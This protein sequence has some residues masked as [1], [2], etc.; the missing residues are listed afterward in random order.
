[1]PPYPKAGRMKKS[2]LALALLL[3]T[4]LHAEPAW[5]ERSNQN[6]RYLIEEQAR[7]VP[8]EA[9]VNGLTRYDGQTMDLGPQLSERR[10]R[11][12]EQ[13][14]AELRKRLA[15]EKVGNV[16]QDLQ[17]LIASVERDSKRL[18]LHSK[19]LLAW[20]DAPGLIFS[21][22]R[23][24]LNDQTPPERRA[25]AVE[26]LQ[27]YVGQ[28]PGSKPLTEL[29]KA[30]FL[31]RRGLLG[32]TRLSVEDSLANSATYVQGIRQLFQKY[33]LKGADASLTLLEQQVADYT[34]WQKTVVLPV[35][36][37][38]F[39]LPPELYAFTLQQWG[40]DVQPEALIQRALLE[41]M[42]T[43]AALQQL[44][45]LVA[46]QKGFSETE[47]PKV[48][49][50]LK[51]EK[52][53]NDRLEAEYQE[54]NNQIEAVIRREKLVDLPNRPMQV[55]LASEA[56][57]AS[58]PAPHMDPPPL[59]NNHGEQG[60]FVLP[61]SVAGQEYDD[62]NF[63]GATWT[64]SAH[65]GRPGHELQF[66]AMVERGVSLARVLYA[67]NSVNVEGWALYSE[68]EMLPHHPL[69][70]QLVALQMRLL[71]AARAFLDPM[72][73]LG[74]I[75]PE[76]ARRILLEQVA[77]SPAMAK[78]EV[79]RYT[80]RHP[81]QAGTYFYGYT[82]ILELRMQTELALGTKFDRLRFNNFLLDQG[83]LPP[84][85]MERAV[86]ENFLPAQQGVS[87]P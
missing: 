66:T 9:S 69:D 49:A 43:R 7:F 54:R 71:R 67:R 32:P 18:Q 13:I 85:L 24:L 58:Q 27:R 57:S 41:Y 2:I 82:R 87:G 8:E 26:M 86:R 4:G 61:V 48:I 36:R 34:E 19:Y 1:L 52:I 42:E 65:E 16:R 55:R 38:D 15:Q 11:S 45:P 53:P 79:D 44:A 35:A 14:L 77:V 47:Y 22:M 51:R 62:F 33:E 6:T 30:R 76:E 28:T 60:T 70:G 10:L 17:I 23:V 25:K 68:A 12:N 72:L 74:R 73:N 75:S 78:Q 56:E 31:E 81:G 39:K 63:P 40:I 80:F 46:R 37:A 29:A 21:C 59:A 50:L 20:V 83:L 3:T 64:V 84:D 5:V